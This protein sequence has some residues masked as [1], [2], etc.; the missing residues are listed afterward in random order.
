MRALMYLTRR[1]LVNNL[2]K[3][4]HRPSTLIALIFGIVY[5]I[6]VVISL[7]GLAAGIRMNSVRGLVI[8]ITVWSIYSTFG[9]FMG[10]SSRIGI[11]F[12]PG[13]AHFVFTAPISPKLVLLNGAWMNYLVSTILWVILAI[14]GL[15]VFQ[16][17]P[18]KVLLFFLTGSVLELALEV[19]VMVFLYTND[20]LPE[21]LMKGIRLAVKVFLIAFTLLIVLYFRRNGMS[22]ESASAFIDWEDRKSV[23]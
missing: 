20:Q 15:T 13:H 17:E 3:A 10:Y 1:S 8:I 9:N 23:V 2:K 21:G 7:G 4:V 22:V 11:L 6:F 18:W 16:V 12:R 19:A 14:G 5:G